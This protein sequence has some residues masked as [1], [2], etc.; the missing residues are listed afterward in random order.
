MCRFIGKAI[1]DKQDVLNL[2]LSNLAYEVT[3]EDD[4]LEMYA[5][6]KQLKTLSGIMDETLALLATSPVVRTKA[7]KNEPL[8]RFVFSYLWFA[9]GLVTMQ[10][11]V[12]TL[13]VP[14]HAV[15]LTASEERSKCL[16]LRKSSAAD[17]A[18]D[19]AIHRA[20]A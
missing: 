8:I 10:G 4:T 7:N 18:N 2:I 16:H 17:I 12:C 3:G 15:Q 19:C 9:T 11:I 5:I 1:S 14:L 20:N 6:E 13:R